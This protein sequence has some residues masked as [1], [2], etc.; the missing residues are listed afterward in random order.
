MADVGQW[1]RHQ[2]MH[3]KPNPSKPK[4]PNNIE[5]NRSQT[6]FKQK[7]KKSRKLKKKRIS[8]ERLEIKKEKKNLGR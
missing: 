6:Y 3:L 1:N 4:N 5:A 8:D 2:V 7:I